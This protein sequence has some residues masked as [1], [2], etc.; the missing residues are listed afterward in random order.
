MQSSKSSSYRWLLF[1]TGLIHY[2]LVPAN[3]YAIESNVEKLRTLQG[4]SLSLFNAFVQIA[5]IFRSTM[6]V[7]GVGLSKF[8][9]TFG[10]EHRK[11]VVKTGYIKHAQLSD[12]EN[13]IYKDIKISPDKVEEGWLKKEAEYLLSIKRTDKVHYSIHFHR[14]YSDPIFRNDKLQSKKRN[15]LSSERYRLQRLLKSLSLQNYKIKDAK[16]GSS[17]LVNLYRL[18]RGIDVAGNENDAPIEIFAPTIRALRGRRSVIPIGFFQ[19]EKKMHLSIHAGEDYSHIWSGMRSIDETILF[20]G[21]QPGDRIGHGLALGVDAH[22]WAKMQQVAYLSVGEHLDNLVWAHHMVQ[23]LPVLTPPLDVAVDAI[24]RKIAKW[25]CKIW[26]K[27]V[28]PEIL[29]RAWMLR[30]NCPLVALRKRVQSSIIPHEQGLLIPDFA[31]GKQP[32]DAE[33]E[34]WREYTFNGESCSATKEKRKVVSVL[35]QE[36]KCSSFHEEEEWQEQMSLAELE[37]VTA[38]QDMLIQRYSE[39]GVLFEACPTSNVYT[40]RLNSYAEHPLFRWYPPDSRLLEPGQQFN[41]YGLRFGPLSVCLN[42]DDAGLMPTTI[43]NEHK[44][45]RDTA[46]KQYNISSEVAEQWIDRIRQI[47]MDIFHTSHIPLEKKLICS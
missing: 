11:G 43:E 22:A 46:I 5:N 42:T 40:A 37:L 14:D 18:V 23:H 32:A 28:S 31:Q 24:A 9:K 21:Y 38:I 20:C 29:Y 19:H 4:D 36:Q 17:F 8:V 13:N 45:M 27:N 7:N 15:K 3:A 44:V 2:H 10:F 34:L 6:I 33:L 25:S 1:A 39:I 30:R 12:S 26:G 41:K 47:G 16:K 35:L